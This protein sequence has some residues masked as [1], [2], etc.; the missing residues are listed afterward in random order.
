MPLELGLPTSCDER[1][2]DR[3]QLVESCQPRPPPR[4]PEARRSPFLF[5]HPA[6]A[7]G[8]RPR[9]PAAREQAAPSPSPSLRFA[10]H[11]RSTHFAAEVTARSLPSTYARDAGAAGGLE[12][13]CKLS[14]RGTAPG[15]RPSASSSRLESM[16]HPP[17]I[18]NLTGRGSARIDNRVHE[19][20]QG[21][22]RITD[23]EMAGGR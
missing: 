6:A 23:K 20:P 12:V 1:R 10:E 5:L 7:A 4:S 11:S 21:K 3:P 9:W 22:E 13:T 18:P 17:S 19:R 14:M 15:T 8:V 2:E 16:T